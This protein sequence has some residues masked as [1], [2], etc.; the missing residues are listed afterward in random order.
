M[1]VLIE[2]K[3]NG[4][5]ASTVSPF[6]VS[7]EGSTDNEALQRLQEQISE[8]LSTDTRIVTLDF[9][10]A[11]DELNKRR[12]K[13]ALMRFAGDLKDSPL[14]EEWKQA[15]AEYRREVEEDERYR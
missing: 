15:M 14:L 5:R 7:A 10:S 9:S 2:K 3:S 4:Y 6:A 13:E 11:T 12:K 8:R 1:E